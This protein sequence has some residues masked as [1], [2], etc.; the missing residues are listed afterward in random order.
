MSYMYIRHTFMIVCLFGID[1]YNLLS[2]KLGLPEIHQPS[3]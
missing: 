1:V 3:V 2:Q